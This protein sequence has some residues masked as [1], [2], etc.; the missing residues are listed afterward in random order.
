MRAKVKETYSKNNAVSFG[1][2]ENRPAG[3]DK[4][5]R[6]PL[7]AQ[8]EAQNAVLEFGAGVESAAYFLESNNQT[9]NPCRFHD[10]DWTPNVLAEAKNVLDGVGLSFASFSKLRVG[11]HGASEFLELATTNKLPRKVCAFARVYLH[12]CKTFVR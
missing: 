2:Y 9:I 7:C 4:L 3:R 5:A 10:H 12:E 11:G 8:L 6:H 1:S